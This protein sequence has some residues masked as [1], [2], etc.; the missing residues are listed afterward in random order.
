MPSVTIGI[1]ASVLLAAA[2]LPAAS[3]H[4]RVAAS[5]P[6]PA[7][8]PQIRAGSLTLSRC[9]TV[10]AYCGSITQPLDPAGQVPGTIQIAFEFYPHLN[11]SQPAAGTIVA[12][13]GGPGYP[14]TG[15][16]VSY[17]DL[18]YPLL[19]THDLL[20]VDNRGTG[21]SQAL[22][23]QPLQTGGN[24]TLHDIALCGASLSPAADLYG[25]GIAAD[26]LA[27]VLAALAIPQIDLYGDS[28]GSYFSQAFAGRH[29]NLLRALIL[30]STWPVVGESPW[31]P[32]AS[33]AMQNA[34]NVTC[35]QN[36]DCRNLPGTSIGRITTL[37][38]ALYAHPFAGSAP[39]GNGNYITVH[40]DGESLAYEAYSNSSDSVV[41]RELDPAA[42]AYLDQ[43]D[44]A[45]LLRLIAE[46]GRASLSNCIGGAP[47][48]YSAALFVAVSCSD[49]PQI[50][51]MTAPP[52]LRPAEDI[53]SI[54]QEQ[55]TD[56]GVYAPFTIADYRLMPLPSSVLDMCLPWPVPSP[57]H[58]PG[59]PVP[60]GTVFPSVPVLVLSG[61][62]DSLTPAQ[63][64]A[65]AAA[66]F[67]NATQILVANSFHVTAEGDQDD[68]ASAIAVHF[69]RDLTPGD[70]SCASQIAEVRMLPRFART[71][72]A[73]DPATPG[74]GNQGTT[75]DLQAA[76]A[77]AL[78]AG[79]AIARWWVNTS[80]SGV[81]L[82]GGQFQ[83]TGTGN[84]TNFTLD[85][86]QWV[87][88]LAV[89]GS[90]VWQYVT[91]G[92]VVA[93]LTFN[94]AAGPG[95]LRI[96]WDDRQPQAQATIQGAIGGR[97]IVATMQAP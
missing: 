49:Y 58:P 26:D 24:G 97:T 45:P 42:R 67:P 38:D 53:A 75:A 72:S 59:Q 82:R 48:C 41:Y 6:L 8:P 68:C 14:S 81:G 3:P 18:F 10:T 86:S 84:I 20:L 91:P 27:A 96:T 21:K 52:S 60:P 44:S 13:E 55:L 5:V 77:A 25:S 74:P 47:S 31:Y 4:R 57:A 22:D 50:Y 7:G 79:D 9:P 43:G 94:T 85:S 78:T 30:D 51:D 37:L 95:A 46:N 73:L 83:Y 2:S 90:I 33:P 23:C 61:E 32:E 19:D 56:P 88:N 40:A 28:Y 17:I 89:S 64:G 93:Q 29:G 12:V 69:F 54:Q 87:E 70:T 11:S 66:L 1:A 76:A 16:R 80:G 65:E 63:Q 35:Q 62:L 71:M 36:V 92:A 39:D 34:F 15:S